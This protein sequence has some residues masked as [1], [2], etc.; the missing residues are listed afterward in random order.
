VGSQPASIGAPPLLV[1]RIRNQLDS[2]IAT[3]GTG[4]MPKHT[5]RRPTERRPDESDV[6]WCDLPV[7]RELDH[8]ESVAGIAAFYLID[9]QRRPKFSYRH[10]ART[11]DGIERQTGAGLASIAHD[12]KPAV[13]NMRSSMTSP[14]SSGSETYRADRRRDPA[15][16]NTGNCNARA[17]FGGRVSAR[18]FRLKERPNTILF[19]RVLAS[20]LDRAGLL[21]GVA[22]MFRRCGLR[23]ADWV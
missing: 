4:P 3:G 6:G 14:I 22:V 2:S 13:V 23:R 17:L 15:P 9:I 10:V 21:F 8:C 20:A 1:F 5:S 12:L 19:V 11:H 7:H 18:G 16:I